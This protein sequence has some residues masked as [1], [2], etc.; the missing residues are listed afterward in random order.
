MAKDVYRRLQEQLDQYSVGFP[1]SKSGIEIQMLKE[2]FTEEE[3]TMF[4]S[5][6]AA[7]ETP[8]AV[9]ARVNKPVEE[10]ASR[11]EDMAKKGLLFR[12]RSGNAKMYSA[13]PFIHGLLEFQLDRSDKDIKKIIK[14]AGQY[15]NEK[16]KHDMAA[17]SD[18]FMRTVPV[19]RSL[20]A[21]S[22]VAPY[23]DAAGILRNEDV[24][25]L[26]DCACRKQKSYFGKDCGKPLDVCFMFGPMGDYYVENG[27]GRKVDLEEALEVLEKGHDAGLITQTGAAM[28]PF[29]LCNCCVCCCG[30]LRAASKHPSP[31]DL[32][33]SNYVVKGEQ[34]KCSGCGKCVS[35]CGM[36]AIKMNEDGVAQTNLK[37]C[38]GCG[39]CVTTCPEGARELVPKPDQAHRVP[40]EDT[41]AQMRELAKERGI[42]RL[43]PT[44]IVSFGF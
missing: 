31:A 14:M 36:E 25:V 33:F 4:T 12:K 42:T 34:D 39:L 6:T 13:I 35:R 37:R 11:L 15:I 40:Q 18:L 22:H 41:P 19:N 17:R 28:K 32:V 23:E 20:S 2:M 7:L 3:A 30:F 16:L 43:D 24:I 21:V 8:E 38:I 1:P 26:T 10:I 29:T 5:L 44:R 27:L 9:S